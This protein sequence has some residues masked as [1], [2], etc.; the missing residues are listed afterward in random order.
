MCCVVLLM[1]LIGP[2]VAFVFAWIFTDEV[3]QAFDNWWVP[4]GGLILLP[5]TALM[6]AIAYAPIGHVSG[7]GWLVVLLGVLLDIGT[8]SSGGKWR[9]Q[10]ASLTRR[11]SAGVVELDRGKYA[12]SDVEE[13]ARDCHGLRQ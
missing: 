1:G 10:S 8:Y 4:L 9:M 2:R 6:Y 3:D 11:S 5:W 13:C 12:S 7:I